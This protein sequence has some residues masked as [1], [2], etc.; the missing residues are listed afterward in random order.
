MPHLQTHIDV[1]RW[2]D[3]KVDNEFILLLQ[4]KEAVWFGMI[5]QDIKLLLVCFIIL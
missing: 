5:I 4:R 1:L 3:T 2:L